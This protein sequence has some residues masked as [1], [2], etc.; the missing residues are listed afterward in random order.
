MP[1]S[2]IESN[3]LKVTLGYTRLTRNNS[4]SSGADS[5]FH[6]TL[7]KLVILIPRHQHQN[8]I[9]IVLHSNPIGMGQFSIWRLS[10]ANFI[11]Y[12]SARLCYAW[13]NTRV[14]RVKKHIA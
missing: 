1:V 9:I 2:V 7:S 10:G 11:I 14:G 8:T 5:I 12:S 3:M 4:K 13:L 6:L